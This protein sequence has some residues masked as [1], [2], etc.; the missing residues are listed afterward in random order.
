MG[1]GFAEGT[2]LQ[3]LSCR[4]NLKDRYKDLLVCV[5]LGVDMVGVPVFFPP[6]YIVYLAFRPTVYSQLGQRVSVSLSPSTA[7]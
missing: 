6:H 2:C 4:V 7:L 1:I 5:A 3:S